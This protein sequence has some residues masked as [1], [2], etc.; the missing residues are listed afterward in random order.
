MAS[1]GREDLEQAVKVIRGG[2]VILYPTD[3][4]WGIGCDAS[5]SEAV[6]RIFEIKKREDS[7]SMLVLVDSVA[8]LNYYV[9]DVPELAYDL[10]DLSDKPLTLIYD[11]ARRIAPQLIAEDGSVGIRV[12]K[13]EFSHDLCARVRGAVVSTSANISGQPSPACFGQIS[14]EILDAVDYVAEYRR[15]DARQ[16][17]PSG[18]VK[19]GAGGLVKVIRE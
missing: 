15:D 11:G 14:R 6:K 12:T 2:G 19:L 17:R 1:Y 8:K 16:A 5:C 10:I 3:T 13:E 9:E 4:V 18:I 7:K